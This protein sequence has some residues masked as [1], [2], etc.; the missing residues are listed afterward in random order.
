M[1]LSMTV[2]EMALHQGE[3]KIQGI[4]ERETF[5]IIIINLSPSPGAREHSTAR[6]RYAHITVHGAGVAVFA[7]AMA[8]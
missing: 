6:A 7:L 1:L 3:Q 8:R 5:E 4:S 2:Y